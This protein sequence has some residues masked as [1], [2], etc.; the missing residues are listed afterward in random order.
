MIVCFLGSF[1][2]NLWYHKPKRTTHSLCICFRSFFGWF[3]TSK[4]HLLELLFL[5]W[6][7][8]AHVSSRVV[9]PSFACARII[10]SVNNLMLSLF[11]EH[12]IGESQGWR[13]LIALINIVKLFFIMKSILEYSST[14]CNRLIEKKRVLS[15]ILP[16]EPYWIP[17][18]LILK[19]LLINM[20]VSVK[21]GLWYSPAVCC[22]AD[23]CPQISNPEILPRITTT[24]KENQFSM[25]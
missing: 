14:G 22:C 12:M 18:L 25:Y 2:L 19:W 20:L 1:A 7:L 4:M 5:S 24:N 23:Y 9:R 15:F 17:C 6:C 10:L 8:S 11:Q 13:N 16:A 21:M 3:D